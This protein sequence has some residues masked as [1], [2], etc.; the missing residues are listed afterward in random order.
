LGLPL[1]LNPALGLSWSF[2]SSGSSPFPSLQFFHIGTIMGG[3]FG[4]PIPHFMPV[5]LLE[6]G[7]T[8]SLSLI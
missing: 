5:F 7:S 3:S 4:N 8:I 2:F 6:V 1:E